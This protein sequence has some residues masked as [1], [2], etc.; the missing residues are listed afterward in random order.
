MAIEEKDSARTQKGAVP[1]NVHQESV[2]PHT[3]GD[4]P[5]AKD[6]LGFAPYVEAVAA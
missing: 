1:L 2:S 3:V 6:A 4:Q 5:T